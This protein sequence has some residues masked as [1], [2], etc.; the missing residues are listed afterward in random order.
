MACT[1]EE[2]HQVQ[3][4]ILCD[5]GDYCE[6][7]NIDY[8][9]HGGTLLGAVRESD[10]I[11]WDDDI[12]VIMSIYEFKR[13]VKLVKKEPLKDMVFQW[14]TTENN[15]PFICAKLRKKNTYVP[16]EL[17]NS[18]NINQ[19]VWIDIFVYVDKPEKNIGILCQEKLMRLFYIFSTEAL[20][21]KYNQNFD[22]DKRAVFLSKMPNWLNNFI[23]RILFELISMYHNKDSEF[24]RDFDFNGDHNSKEPRSYFEP[25]VLHKFRDKELRVPKN[26]DKLLTNIY[27]ND[28]M[29][30]R[31]MHT[32]T[33]LE[34]INLNVSGE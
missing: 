13:F 1:F 12:D 23:R 19:G 25:T 33:E 16:E 11:P 5:F 21:K 26:F 20:L 32:H 18:F 27:G 4:E 31:R 24:V 3:Y 7:H 29:T 6:K 15:T 10:F 2:L 28:Y 9:L 8:K 34:N 30:P 22:V 14:I 17:I